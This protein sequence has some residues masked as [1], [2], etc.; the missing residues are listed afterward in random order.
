M[1]HCGNLLW[2]IS[3]TA[4]CVQQPK[5]IRIFCIHFIKITRRTTGAD[6]TS[7]NKLR[8]ILSMLNHFFYL[9]QSILVCFNLSRPIL[10]QL[11]LSWFISIYHCP[12]LAILSYPGPFCTKIWYFG[13]SW[14]ISSY[15]RLSLAISGIL[16]YLHTCILA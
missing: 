7:F 9:S 14:A 16:A 8:T 12:Y 2:N 1:L 3:N 11:C 6:V 5:L 15:L 4:W 13:L 10:V